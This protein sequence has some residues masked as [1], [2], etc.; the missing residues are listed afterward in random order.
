MSL[1]ANISLKAKMSFVSVI[2]Q[3]KILKCKYL[4]N[5]MSKQKLK[6]RFGISAKNPTTTILILSRLSYN[7]LLSPSTFKLSLSNKIILSNKILFK[8][9]LSNKINLFCS[10]L[11]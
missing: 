9:I 1:N 7:L 11:D 4:E 8:K 3:K 2:N 10:V 5:V 6:H